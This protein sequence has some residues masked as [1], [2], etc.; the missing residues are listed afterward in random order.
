VRE[1]LDV[2]EQRCTVRYDITADG[3]ARA[4]CF[5]MESDG[6]V[7]VRRSRRR[8]R[9]AP[10]RG[11]LPGSSPPE[12]PR[13]RPRQRARRE[14]DEPSGLAGCGVGDEESGCVMSG[15]ENNPAAGATSPTEMGPV[16]SSHRSPVGSEPP[17][18]D[19]RVPTQAS[20]DSSSDTE[21]L[22]D[23]QARLR[24]LAAHDDGKVN[25][26]AGKTLGGARSA[27]RQQPRPENHGGSVRDEGAAEVRAP[28][29]H[30]GVD[31]CNQGRQEQVNVVRRARSGESATKRHVERRH[32]AGDSQVRNH[33]TRSTGMRDGPP[34]AT[35]EQLAALSEGS[36]PPV[37]VSREVHE[38]IRD[39]VRS[40]L[41][42]DDMNEV[43]CAVCDRLV[44][45]SD[46]DTHALTGLL[47]AQIVRK[48][49]LPGDLPPLLR[50]QYDCSGLLC[51]PQ[52][53][54]VGLSP[55]GVRREADG[56]ALACICHACYT[57]VRRTGRKTT[58]P[59]FSIA[60]G[61]YV[62]ALP[63]HLRDSTWLELRLMSMVTPLMSV[64]VVRGG[65]NRVIR[66]HVSLYD[67]RP[68]SLVTLL[69]RVLADTNDSFMVI[70]SG[71]MTP[72]QELAVRRSHRVRGSRLNE[73]Y[74][75]FTSHNRLYSERA[76]RRRAGHFVDQDPVF[77]VAQGG[78]VEST[79][80]PTATTGATSTAADDFEKAMDADQSNV[81]QR[82]DADEAASPE[83]ELFVRSA[84]GVHVSYDGST[85]AERLQ[86]AGPARNQGTS[87]AGGPVVIRQG[88]ALVPDSTPY[89]VEMLVPGLI[90]FGRG[91]PDEP[92]AVRVSKIECLRHYA[93]LS[94][95]HFAQD[96]VYTLMAFD[97][98]ARHQ[99]MAQASLYCR[100]SST[101][102]NAA[103]ANVTPQELSAL[104]DYDTACLSAA[105][106]NLPRPPM[107]PDVGRAKTLTNRVR[108]AAAHGKGSN[109]ARQVHL[110]RGFSLQTRFGS[111]SL[112]VTISPKD[113]GSLTVAYLAGQVA[114]D[115]LEQIDITNLPSQA[116]R[117]AATS[118]D[119]VACAR[120]FNR[121]V[122]CFFQDVVGYDREEQRPHSRGGIFGHVK[123]YIAGF[124][125]QGDGTLHFHSMLWLYG[126]AGGRLQLENLLKNDSYK[127]AFSAFA[128]SVQC[129]SA[130]LPA[131]ATCPTCVEE[132]GA[133]LA[134][135]PPSLAF[136][137]AAGRTVAPV[138]ARCVTCK[139]EFGHGDLIEASLRKGVS[140]LMGDD[141]AVDFEK[142]LRPLVNLPPAS[143]TS[144]PIGKIFATNPDV[145]RRELAEAVITTYLVV[146]CNLHRWQHCESCFKKSKRTQGL[147]VG[148][149]RYLYPREPEPV[150]HFDEDMELVVARRVGSE[151]VNSYSATIMLV[152]PTNHDIRLLARHGDM[153]YSLK[154]AFKDQ[155]QVTNAAILVEAFKRRVARDE[156]LLPAA[157]N[158]AAQRRVCS[159]VHAATKTQEIA[160]P[161]AAHY[162]LG[163][164]GMYASHEFA[165]LLLGQALAVY[166]RDAYECVVDSGA[167]QVVFSS[168]TDDY[169]HRPLE[170]ETIPHYWFVAGYEKVV[171]RSIVR[172]R[173]AFRSREVAE[174]P[175]GG[176]WAGDGT[177]LDVPGGREPMQFRPAHPQAGTHG[178]VARRKLFVPDVI[179]PRIP[180]K[181]GFARPPVTGAEREASDLYALVVLLLFCPYRSR[182]PA[183]A[184]D[185][186]LLASLELWEETADQEHFAESQRVL[187]N[188]QDYYVA[189]AAAKASAEKKRDD[190]REV[191]GREDPGGAGG[192]DE[193][194][195]RLS[196]ASDDEGQTDRLISSSPCDSQDENA[197]VSDAWVSRRR[198]VER[199]SEDVHRACDLA[200]LRG[201]SDAVGRKPLVCTSAAR[202]VV[203]DVM[204]TIEAS[205][206][207]VAVLDAAEDAP[208]DAQGDVV[209]V[210]EYG[211]GGG[212]TVT[213]ELLA[214]AMR[215]R[216]RRDQLSGVEVLA[217]EVECAAGT[218]LSL[219]AVSAGACL[220]RRQHAAFC[221]IGHRLLLDFKNALCGRPREGEPLRMILHG[222]GG[223]GKSRVLE[224]LTTLC[225]AWLKPQALAL[226]AP[227]GIAAVNIGGRTVHSATGM[228][229]RGGGD[230]SAAR[231]TLSKAKKDQLIREWAACQL[232]A[233]DEM[234]M[235]DKEM[236]QE[237][238]DRMEMAKEVKGSFGLMHLILCGDFTQLPPVAGQPLY[239]ASKKTGVKGIAEQAGYN[240]Y[241]TFDTVVILEENMRAMADPEWKAVLCR[242]RVG[243]LSRSD[244]ALLSGLVGSSDR[245][246]AIS[247]QL[248]AEQATHSI[249]PGAVAPLPPLCP[250]I[251]A[252]NKERYDII[253]SV[254]AAAA[255]RN[256]D[257]S[258]RPVLIPG[259]LPAVK[260]R[261]P[262]PAST[263]EE[264]FALDDVHKMMPILPL[265]HNM[266]YMVSHNVSVALN[267]ANGTL[268]YPVL[269]QFSASCTFEQRYIGD[270][271]FDLASEPAELIWARV[272][273]QDFS[274]QFIHPAGIPV[275]AFPLLPFLGSGVVRLPNGRGVSVTLSQFPISP[276]CA[277]TVHKVQGLT[278]PAAAI[279]RLRGGRIKSP[280]TGLY[281]ASSRTKLAMRTVFLHAL[282]PRDVEYFKPPVTL[283]TELER[284]ENLCV[285]TMERFEE[286]SFF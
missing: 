242:M 63:D 57:S 198:Q 232:V 205:R 111:A 276:A 163:G 56:R 247:E 126:M 101:E 104:L 202:A 268:C 18:V 116:A 238:S 122:R 128:D 226:L 13:S 240:L 124:E 239:T 135:E 277:I 67:A 77:E 259:Y 161:L 184:G 260:N 16:A 255:K 113:N 115:K 17:T 75:F 37:P 159:L 217:A 94:L 97:M 98:S 87:E 286:H 43:T 178:I 84:G 190:L 32:R 206:R 114:C 15:I 254:V 123:A 139:S 234:S 278:L 174:L 272:P 151:Y 168:A 224:C 179:G 211:R 219:E 12:Y 29:R 282:A 201:V 38:A 20:P 183:A 221:I 228:R 46:A 59:R 165:P 266:P 60:N 118:K 256:A 86:A 134:V 14:S 121:I 280:K 64:G 176:F 250:V 158:V 253:W 245:L 19:V 85:M 119:P 83:E 171:L 137:R 107:P 78:S 233:I 185:G 281:V 91:G 1:V 248:V 265:L 188:A 181:N 36:S 262:L 65:A 40:R 47:L 147:S 187:T 143:W 166:K 145:R 110:R 194:G 235:M 236:L 230:G 109:P 264:L 142:E 237:V 95:R 3:A 258:R 106:D 82:V 89:L 222:E 144:L 160:A 203:A 223:T 99:A 4:Q 204:A 251:V 70:L 213:V 136:T 9:P 212:G 53:G 182:F 244:C 45:A 231:R 120:Y 263:V 208:R 22:A 284:L 132:P 127:A 169:R 274:E 90:A 51:L 155:Q 48:L 267:V 52:L 154:Y 7:E 71:L 79:S 24:R 81:R 192:A 172:N 100:L 74:E 149:C 129:H 55:R 156:L 229:P 196:D 103:I 153:Y 42:G 8:K 26:R 164:D 11:H 112:F 54:G 108:A 270:A 141:S 58:P 150:T 72:A 25:L 283:M 117:F 273:G 162:L 257:P 69:P 73:L 157:P 209:A 279:S 271:V 96:N 170:L 173:G 215:R 34:L 68:S 80:R 191:F 28:H 10:C 275:D 39:V 241:K 140:E 148:A 167:S 61:F 102:Q 31:G 193:D 186:S 180:D 210:N 197:G 27:P 105:R 76:V 6:D 146:H 225:K 93:L 21:P 133:V 200:D 62:G 23:R 285:S 5:L 214:E 199:V 30:G 2:V 177:G 246:R 207:G 218:F 125:T 138:T 35:D 243:A 195:E 252:T 130:P 261:V 227:T 49:K 249:Q 41:W 88:G 131:E 50:E 216:R 33:S 66:S 220:N 92:R 269:A 175:V 44:V 152:L 189:K